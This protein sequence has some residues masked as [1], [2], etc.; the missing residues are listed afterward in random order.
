MEIE[1]PAHPHLHAGDGFLHPAP[2]AAQRA[3]PRPRHGP[4]AVHLHR[5]DRRAGRPR[6]RPDRTEELRRS[7]HGPLSSS[8]TARSPTP[9]AG[10]ALIGPLRAGGHRVIAYANPLRGVATDAAP[11]SDLVADPRRPD[12]AGRSLLRRRCDHHGGSPEPA[13]SLPLSTSQG[14]PCSPARAPRTRR[15]WLRDRPWATRSSRCRSSPAVSTSTSTRR[16]TTTSS[17]P[18]WPRTRRLPWRSPS[19]R[20]RRPPSTSPLGD[21]A[22]WQSVPS[23]FIFGSDDRNIPAGAHQVMADRAGARRTVQVPGAS[24]VVGISHPDDVAALVLE[25]AAPTT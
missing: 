21:R 16:S 17:A 19:V 6:S 20:S 11:L 3:R 8:F 10:T 23:W 2:D 5:R 1:G 15:R 13:T 4:D 25:A 7:T 14:S 9:P 18:I 12:R 22:L 24:H